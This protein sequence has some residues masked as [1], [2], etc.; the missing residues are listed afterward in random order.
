[1]RVHLG[2]MYAYVCVLVAQ[3][4]PS[5]FLHVPTLFSM[6]LLAYILCSLGC[7]LFPQ[8]TERSASQPMCIH[9]CFTTQCIFF[10]RLHLVTY[11][12]PNYTD[13][14]FQPVSIHVY[15]SVVVIIIE[16]FLFVNFKKHLK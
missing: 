8:H 15:G 4:F 3:N 5:L 6:R 16:N 9:D 2:C 12:G 7:M 10:F 13:F 14:I 11:F 1:M